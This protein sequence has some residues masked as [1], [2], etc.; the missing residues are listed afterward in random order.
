[1]NSRD[2]IAVLVLSLLTGCAVSSPP[3]ERALHRSMDAT[4]KALDRADE[5]AE[6][7]D[8][9]PLIGRYNRCHCP[10]PDFEIYTYG[11]WRRVILGGDADLLAELA[12]EMRQASDE[13]RLATLKLWGQSEARAVHQESGVEYPRFVVRRFAVQ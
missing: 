6:E 9:I 5:A 12:Q 13:G 4:A 3:N 1:M 11:R 2:A 8:Q 7:V 10:A